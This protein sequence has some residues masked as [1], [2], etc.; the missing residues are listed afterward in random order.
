MAGQNI[1]V[2]A[3]ISPKVIVSQQLGTSDAALYTVPTATSVKVAHGAL[4][5]VTSSLVTAA[6]AGTPTAGVAAPTITLGTTATTGGTFAAATYFWKVTTLTAFGETTGSNELTAAIAANGTQVI[7]WTALTNATGYKV[8]RGS[9]TNTENILVATLGTVVTYTD[10]GIAGTSTAIPTSNTS[11]AY[12]WKITAKNSAGESLP[13]NEVSATVTAVQ[14]EPL[15]WTAVPTATSYNVYRGTAAGAEGVLVA[16]VTGTSYTD[17]G[18]TGTTQAL[19]TIS[20][21]ATAVTVYLSVIASGG[22]VGDGTHRIIHNYP[23]LGNDTLTLKDY[24]GGAMLGPGD[25]IAAY[26]AAANSVDLVIT[27]TVHA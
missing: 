11:A 16:N 17:T 26:A 24:L 7:N 3:S 2:A 9:A 10:T 19:P 5:N 6:A 23:L 13:S 25:A 8:Y 22:T 1:L 21:Y 12:F 18:A 27:G 20:T 14:V 4:C 15:S